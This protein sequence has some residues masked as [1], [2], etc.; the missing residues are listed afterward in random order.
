MAARLSFA[1]VLLGVLSFPPGALACKVIDPELQGGYAG[2]CVNGLAE[3]EGYATG[4][5][6]YRG[7]FKAGRKD[8]QG[9]KTWPNGDRYEGQF[10]DGRKQGRG[11]YAWG[12]GPWQGERYEGEFAN[13][14]R[15]GQGSYHYANG[16][17][18]SG[19]WKDDVPVGAPTPMM[20]AQRKF[21]E[22]AREAVAKKGQ[23]VCRAMP[24]GIARREWVRGTVVG[25]DGDRVAVRIDQPGSYG[26][27]IAGVALRKDE[28]IWD[29]P[30]GWTPC[31]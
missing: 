2:P 15:N 29:A 23:K 28:V 25:V 17:V 10:V 20:L 13:D 16:D 11:T 7:Q 3:G 14:R 26:E 21:R 12:R 9:V 4:I 31:W 18:Y 22:E 6:S 27:E 24:V 19:Q 8:G 1:F 5:A 30:Y